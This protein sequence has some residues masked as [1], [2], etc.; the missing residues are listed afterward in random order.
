MFAGSGCGRTTSGLSLLACCVLGATALLA[1]ACTDHEALVEP[2]CRADRD[3]AGPGRIRDL[4]G[5]R[6]FRITTS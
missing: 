1:S 5:R 3:V 2:D 4:G 6:R